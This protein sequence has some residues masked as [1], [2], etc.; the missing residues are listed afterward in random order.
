MLAISSITKRRDARLL[1][2][3]KKCTRHPTNKR[4]FPRNPNQLVEPQIRQREPFKVNFTRTEI[5]KKSTIPTC[6]RLLN[7][8]YMEHPERLWNGRA[9]GGMPRGEE[10]EG[11][12]RGGEEERR[13]GEEER[14]GGEEGREGGREEGSR[15][16]RP[17]N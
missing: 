15:E 2:Y 6:Q 16:R 4:F 5:Y 17:G 13:G 7:D 9:H 14:R 1:S 11:R 8:Y 12:R 10:G 3:A